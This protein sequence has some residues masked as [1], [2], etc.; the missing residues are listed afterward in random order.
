[1]ALGTKSSEDKTH[2]NQNTNVIYL[3]YIS[4]TISFLF[5]F[6]GLLLR[7]KKSGKDLLFKRLFGELENFRPSSVAKV[8]KSRILENLSKVIPPSYKKGLVEKLSKSGKLG[9]AAF[10]TVVKQKFAYSIATGV[11]ASVYFLPSGSYFSIFLAIVFGFFLPDILVTNSIQKR[12]E[13]IAQALPDAV[14][15]LTMCVEAGLSFQQSLQKVSINQNT[16]ISNEFARVMSEIQIGEPRV[17]ALTNMGQRL[18][19]KDV[20]KFVSA[21]SQVDRLGIP[22]SSVLREQVQELRSQSRMRAREKAGKV[23]VKILG[24]V[25][26]C[27]MPCTLIVVLAPVILQFVN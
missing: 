8:N 26:A 4:I 13:T 25:M 19:H 20:Q 16:V 27:F 17:V 14:E 5:I 23:P 18:N 7:R 9:D 12:S 2:M 15:M 10:N 24:P 21:M 11:I 22:I 3:I 6:W 1:L